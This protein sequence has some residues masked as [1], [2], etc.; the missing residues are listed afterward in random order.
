MVRL[1]RCA[2]K[3]CGAV[4]TVLPAVIARHLWRS[5]KTV[6]EVTAG[7]AHAPKTT[8]RRW[9]ERFRSSA[10]GLVQ[11]LLAVAGDLLPRGAS[12]VL[13]KA[14]TRR[15]LLDAAVASGAVGSAAPLSLLAAWIHRLEAGI[16]FL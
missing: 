14:Q 16:R 15:E 5:W 3:T 7:K 12:G 9:L 1:Y 4:F 11:L 8:S 2:R 6:E 13:A 10:A